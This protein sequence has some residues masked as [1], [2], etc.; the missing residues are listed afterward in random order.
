MDLCQVVGCIVEHEGRLLLCR[1][2]I[3]PCH[4]LWTLPAGYLEVGEGSAAGAARETWEE[5]GARVEVPVHILAFLPV[6]LSACYTCVVKSHGSLCSYTYNSPQDAGVRGG[7]AA[8]VAREIQEV[9]G[10]K[11]A[12]AHT[13]ILPTYVLLP[14]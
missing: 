12:G 11:D 6:T 9:A 8:G 2:A 10:V 3:Q 4:G 14:L 7:S 13:S 5:A 1:R